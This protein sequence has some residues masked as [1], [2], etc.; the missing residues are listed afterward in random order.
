[1]GAATPALLTVIAK[2]TASS[3]HERLMGH[4]LFRGE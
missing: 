4:L 3:M 1:M 2:A